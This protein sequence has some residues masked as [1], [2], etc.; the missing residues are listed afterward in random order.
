MMTTIAMAQTPPELTDEALA[1]AAQAGDTTAFATLAE[2]YRVVAFAYANACLRNRDEAGDA[3][4][5]AFVRMYQSLARFR[6]SECWGAWMM[7]IVRNLC[8]D[9]LR[10]R[11]RNRVPLDEV[12]ELSAGGPSPEQFA[13]ASAR[14]KELNRAIAALPDQYRIPLL[15]HYAS[16]RTYREIALALGL[17]ES[18][19]G[20]RLAGALRRLRRRLQQEEVR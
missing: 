19:I 18:T 17:P 4:Q 2:R 3:V 14:T 16:G 1:K 13:L 20:G 6:V 15:M 11:R 10:R 7:R 9:T 12:G 5:E 8:T